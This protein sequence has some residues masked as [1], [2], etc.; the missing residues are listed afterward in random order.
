LWREIDVYCG[1]SEGK[2]KFRNDLGF[3]RE[4]RFMMFRKLKIKSKGMKHG[5]FYISPQNS[6]PKNHFRDT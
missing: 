3:A 2:D 6:K 4:K 1:S 5:L